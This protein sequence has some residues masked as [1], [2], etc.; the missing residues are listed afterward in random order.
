MLSNGS[1]VY[2]ICSIF[3]LFCISE[4]QV[5]INQQSS[6]KILNLNGL[7]TRCPNF[8]IK[9]QYF[10]VNKA[11]KLLRENF[12]FALRTSLLTVVSWQ[13]YFS[14]QYSRTSI[15]QTCRDLGK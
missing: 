10:P 12:F 2:S 13:F 8:L 11:V 15:I 4:L 3:N 1:T 6:A 5:K 14:F 7:D 9:N